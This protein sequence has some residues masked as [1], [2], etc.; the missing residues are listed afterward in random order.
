M[1]GDMQLCAFQG[2]LQSD[3]RTSSRR[4]STSV[5]T[6][7]SQPQFWGTGCLQRSNLTAR[8][9]RAPNELLIRLI[10]LDL[11]SVMAVPDS[12]ASFPPSRQ[13]RTDAPMA[14]SFVL[15]DSSRLTW[16]LPSRAPH[17]SAWPFAVLRMID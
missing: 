8:L 10:A 5:D 15:V 6:V 3:A 9:Q 4:S 1:S 2:F 16:G 11:L 17:L 13:P 12:R 7:R 14:P